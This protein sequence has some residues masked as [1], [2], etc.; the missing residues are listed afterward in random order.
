MRR[1]VQLRRPTLK[2][3]HAP[4]GN[5]E[6]EAATADTIRNI[7]DEGKKALAWTVNEKGTQ[8]FFLCSDIDGIITD[9]PK[10]GMKIKAGLEHR[11]DIDRI[12]DRVKTLL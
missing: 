4:G 12:V 3:E 2:H 6:E 8:K 11:S 1:M 7:H 10:Q 5:C 9:E